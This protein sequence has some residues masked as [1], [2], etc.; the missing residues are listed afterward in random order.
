MNP[1]PHLALD[2]AESPPPQEVTDGEDDTSASGPRLVSFQTDGMEEDDE[3]RARSSV[4]AERVSRAAAVRSRSRSRSRSPPPPPLADRGV[5]WEDDNDSSATPPTANAGSRGSRSGLSSPAIEPSLSPVSASSRSRRSGSIQF[6]NEISVIETITEAAD[7]LRRG[8]HAQPGDVLGAADR[9]V[10][11]EDPEG[12][13]SPPGTDI[14]SPSAGGEEATADR[15]LYHR[16]SSGRVV[17]FSAMRD[18][19]VVDTEHA[20]AGSLHSGGIVATEQAAAAAQ[21]HRTGTSSAGSSVVHFSDEIGGGSDNG[22]EDPNGTVISHHLPAD[23]LPGHTTVFQ[24]ESELERAA[25]RLRRLI[26]RAESVGNTTLEEAFGH[27]DP[28]NSGTITPTD[29]RN[30]L[31]RLGESFASYS[32]EDCAALMEYWSRASTGGSALN[33]ASEPR[34]TLLGFFRAMGRHSPPPMLSDTDGERDTDENDNNDD[35]DDVGTP[36]PSTGQSTHT[37]PR[38]PRRRHISDLAESPV[39]HAHDAADRLRDI[40]LRAER[41]EGRPVEQSFRMLDPDGNGHIDA[42]DFRRGLRTLGRGRNDAQATREGSIA[43][44]GAFS[45]IDDEDCEELVALFDANN[46]GLVSLLD[47]Y[48]FIGRHSPPPETAATSGGTS[49][50]GEEG[51]GDGE[52][53]ETCVAA[54]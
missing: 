29:L 42:E 6:N 13:H 24:S 40:V 45:S 33:G 54:A 39:V 43:Y 41:E 34:M 12:P 26:L 50:S 18:V 1:N 15:P 38:T 52:M 31:A 36:F 21:H 11:S 16:T 49:S 3:T 32:V 10:E 22:G 7:R 47:F 27:F 9:Q 37:A 48:R 53:E 20:A 2:G 46:D 19:A 17:H 28:T 51:E 35:D 30:G 4:L 5:S 23:G 44:G 14:P 8:Q 25:D